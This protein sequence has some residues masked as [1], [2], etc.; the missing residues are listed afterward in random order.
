LLGAQHPDPLVARVIHYLHHAPAHPWTVA[1]LA[2]RSACPGRRSPVLTRTRIDLAARAAVRA[3]D[4]RRGGRGRVGCGSPSA[5]SNAFKRVRGI[6]P[7][8]HRSSLAARRTTAQPRRR[9]TS[10]RLTR[11]TGSP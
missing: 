5:L 1:T 9:T 11:L 6:R 10:G 3:R 2:R 4:H 8:E 7:D